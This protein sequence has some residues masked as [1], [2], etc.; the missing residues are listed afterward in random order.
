MLPLCRD[1]HLRQR[2]EKPPTCATTTMG[3]KWHASESNTMYLEGF[4]P[5]QEAS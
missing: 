2:K 1:A 5:Y 4:Y 3:R